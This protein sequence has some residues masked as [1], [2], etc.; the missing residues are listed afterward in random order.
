MTCLTFTI[1][2]V[3]A[4]VAQN[5]SAWRAQTCSTRI[6]PWLAR[7]VLLLYQCNTR[8]LA[9]G[10]SGLQ[11]DAFDFIALGIGVVAALRLSA[12]G[13]APHRRLPRLRH[14]QA[15]YSVVMAGVFWSV[16][17]VA[18]LE[19]LK[20]QPWYSGGNGTSDQVTGVGNTADLSLS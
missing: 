8:L 11:S 14:F 9:D 19:L 1:C 16:M 4:L 5:K 15:Y 20:R 7:V 18:V 17:Y 6:Q 10:T 2:L 13:L 12:D 3:P